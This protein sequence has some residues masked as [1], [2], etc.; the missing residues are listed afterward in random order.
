MHATEGASNFNE[1]MYFNFYDPEQRLGGFVRLGNRPNERY[2]EQTTCLYLPDGRVGFMFQRP[3]ISSN[4]HFDAGGCRFEVVTPFEDLA[5]RYEGKLVLLDRPLEMADPR[6]AFRDNPWVEAS[7]DLSYRGLSPMYGGEP[8][9]DDGQPLTNVDN[10]FAKGH[11]EQHVGARG[12]VRV[13]DDRWEVDGHGLRDHSWGPRFWQAPWWY[14]WLTGNCGDD[15][16][17]MLS[18]IAGRDG[19]R[20][21]GGMI[22]EDGVYKRVRQCSIRTGWTGEGSYH[23]TIRAVARTDEREYAISGDVLSLIPLRNRRTTPDGEKLL[24]R[25]SEGMTEWQVEAVGTGYGL[26]EYL[27]Q[28]VDAV[29]VGVEEEDGA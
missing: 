14:R 21:R 27:D 7:I 17:F 1:S 16:G 5:V 18:I 20:N 4:E 12:S 15:F 8:V 19:K 25:I 13:G 11:Y 10:D 23:Q 28:I 3:E 26:S 9:G 2:A 29:P 24:T 6:K 22:F